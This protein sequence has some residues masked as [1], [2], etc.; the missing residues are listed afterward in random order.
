[1]KHKDVKGTDEV[2]GR[3]REI[4]D[5]KSWFSRNANKLKL[6]AGLS[7]AL[8][9]SAV[10]I[11]CGDD[12]TVVCEV[13]TS[14]AN[15]VSCTPSDKCV[16][17]M[18]K[19][20]DAAPVQQDGGTAQEDSGTVPD[21][22][23]NTGED[24]SVPEE[25][26]VCVP[27]GEAD[28]GVQ[29]DA[30]ADAPVTQDDA[31]APQEDASVPQDDAGVVSCELQSRSN[32]QVEVSRN[33]KLQ[34]VQ[35]GMDLCEGTVAEGESVSMN[36]AAYV[37]AS[38]DDFSLEAAKGTSRM[39]ATKALAGGEPACTVFQNL[40]EQG[41]CY[42]VLGANLKYV[43]MEQD[44]TN[45]TGRAKVALSLFDT[46]PSTLTK[47]FVISEGESK[48]VTLGV[49]LTATCKLVRGVDGKVYLSVSV[50]NSD[51][52]DTFKAPLGLPLKDD[53]SRGTV[54]PVFLKADSASDNVNAMC[55]E[56]SAWLL[57]AGQTKE[58]SDTGTANIGSKNYKVVVQ[59]KTD[60]FGAVDT[61]KTYVALVDP[62]ATQNTD[63]V[64]KHG[65]TKTVNG[66]SVTVAEVTVTPK[67]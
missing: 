35:C 64:I 63:N 27:N 39:V 41:S 44:I 42:D 13:V 65:E 40:V 61:S 30:A 67:Q 36:G 10:A 52:S 11:G 53:G 29:E 59:A 66:V 14:D 21:T 6:A 32:A 37:V 31:G 54:G 15:E 33:A 4:R 1:L 5:G 16:K 46:F 23:P 58:F 50:T 7:V 17:V 62:T 34:G 57:V 22:P 45:A 24:A 38:M 48:K 43:E 9:T 8:G 19:K 26:P 49:Y 20:E 25:Y 28:A 12:K 60:E 3:S 55:T 2:N 18:K 56:V 51:T 47:E